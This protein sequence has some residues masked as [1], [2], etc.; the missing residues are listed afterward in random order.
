M[1]DT[2][3]CDIALD[4]AALDELNSPEAKALLDTIDSLRELQI[5]KIIDLPQIVVVGDQSSGKSSVLEAISRVRFP[6]KGDLCTRFATELVLR[7]DSKT[8]IGVTIIPAKSSGSSQH[9][10]RTSFNKDALAEIISEA[11]E[12]M[13]IRQTG[14]SQDILRVEISGPDI[15][16][17]TLIDLPGFFHSETSDQTSKD[18]EIT[19]QLAEHYMKQPK[20]IILAV[21]SANHN[22]AGQIV[23]QEALKHDP[24][25]E[26]TL[27]VIT[28]PDLAGSQDEKKC[29]QLVRGEESKHKLK[30]GWHVLRNRPEGEENTSADD[31]DADEEKF[32]RTSAW[33]RF[34]PTSCGIRSLRKKL[35]RA[36]LELIQKTL[37]GVIVQIERNLSTRQHDLDQLGKPRSELA[38]LR[39][40]LLEIAERFQRLAFDG[41]DGH[42]G[43]EF[44]G[45]LYDDRE[46]RKLRAL[47]RR[48][49]S[50]FYATLVTKGVGREIEW[51]DDDRISSHDGGFSWIRDGD[52]VPEYL[53]TYL[54]L[55]DG[56]REPTTISES[57]LCEEL[58][59][60]AAAN[61]GTEFPGLPNGKLGFQLFKMQAQPW[62]G[63]ADFYLDKV[64][65]FAESFVEELFTHIIGADERT[66]NAI[67]QFCVVE[68]FEEK[69][70]VLKDK[71]Q[72]ILRPYVSAYG[73]T[74]DA[75]FYATL[76]SRTLEREAG[77]IAS[78]LEEKFPAAFTE[79]GG[80]G[81]IRENVE[82]A[83]RNTENAR[84]GEFGT[85]MVIDMT[86]THFQVWTLPYLY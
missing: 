57:D 69:R 17:V 41:V 42:Y 78:L 25:R 70:K 60:L 40:Y 58:E 10:H 81:L 12:K 54:H 52:D 21:V 26:R 65:D 47:L 19:K 71:L 34:A 27:G 80:K 15:Y 67:L 31:R 1:G 46:T 16:P 13:G 83:I 56:F 33:P 62:H 75:E 14:F 22:L 36:L 8:K 24:K 48:L 23:I 73:S 64:T 63:I 32:F 51:E 45:D 35:S 5:D 38:D 43:D 28:K 74:L 55:F 72:E 53:K 77:R 61:Q 30:L 86:M 4:S 50:A 79:K 18:R 2:R 84:A 3:E 44:F 29:F 9:F 49:N 59:E 20:S 37:P 76:S 82:L 68:F 7:R 85:E 66:V 39:A 6:T 11:T